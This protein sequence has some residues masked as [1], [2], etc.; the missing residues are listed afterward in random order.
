M[1]RKKGVKKTEIS[2]GSEVK[3]WNSYRLFTVPYFFVTSFRYSRLDTAR[4]TAILILK[5]TEGA[6]SGIIALGG[7]GGSRK[8]EA[9]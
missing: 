9:L 3:H 8:I 4:L 7:G 6:V 2:K 1:R 5:C